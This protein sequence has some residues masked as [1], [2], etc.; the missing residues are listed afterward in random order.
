MKKKQ[1][2]QS[3]ELLAQYQTIDLIK[4]YINLQ[5]F[6]SLTES[7]ILAKA[8]QH[9]SHKPLSLVSTVALLT[10]LLSQCAGHKYLIVSV[11]EIS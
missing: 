4:L 11:A 8:K 7:S 9:S 5:S 6:V 2:Y 1:K 3:D 10:R